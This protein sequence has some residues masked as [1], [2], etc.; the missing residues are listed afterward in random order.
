MEAYSLDLRERICAACDEGIETRQEV[1]ERYGVSR[2]FVQKLLRR[3]LSGSIEPRPRGRGPTP[4]IGDQDRRRLSELV[5]QKPDATLAELRVR[6]AEVGGVGVSAPTL[7]RALRALRLVLKNK[8]LHASE[9]DTPRVRALRGHWKKRIRQVDVKKLVF[10]DESGVNTAMTR[11]RARASPG[12]R[13]VGSVPQGH[14]KT[15]TMLGALRL[16]GMTAAATIDAATDTDVFGAFVRHSLVPAL[17]GGDVVVWDNLAP[18]KA[19]E[20]REQIER[21]Q[22]ELIPLPPYSPDLSPIEPCWS[23]IKQRVRSTEPRTVDALGAVTAKAFAAITP[24]DAR[25]WFAKCGYC[26]H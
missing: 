7:C 14:W 2:S 21:K 8:T 6:L 9:R 19:Q 22:A 20:V 23:K 3:R 16:D 12:E 18:H 1:A 4:L 24:A 26:V 5:K 15:L 11:T 17:R 13:A 10:V 25:G